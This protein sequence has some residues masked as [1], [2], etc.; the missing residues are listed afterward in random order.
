MGRAVRLTRA[1]PFTDAKW[2]DR[3]PMPPLDSNWVDRY[4]VHQSMP[5]YPDT[6]VNAVPETG[7]QRQVPNLVENYYPN[8][9]PRRRR[10]R[11]GEPGG[12][13]KQARRARRRT[14]RWYQNLM[15]RWQ[16][17]DYEYDDDDDD[18]DG[19]LISMVSIIITL[20]FLN[21]LL[22]FFVLFFRKS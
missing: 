16:P 13:R 8:G 22:L 11:D 3:V 4:Q 14:P 21:V 6:S 10:R 5:G 20:L 18:D 1:P 2:G 7:L 15:P 9:A 19:D 17:R 12:M